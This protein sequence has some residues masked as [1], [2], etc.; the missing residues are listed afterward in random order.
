MSSLSSPTIDQVVENIMEE[1]LRERAE[2]P[3]NQETGHIE[4]IKEETEEVEVEAGEVRVFF[5][6]NGA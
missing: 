5:I 6:E 3:E 1:V 4:E 2:Q